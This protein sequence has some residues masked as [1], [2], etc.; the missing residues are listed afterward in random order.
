MSNSTSVFLLLLFHHVEIPACYQGAGQC[1]ALPSAA[2]PAQQALEREASRIMLEVFSSQAGLA[3][4]IFFAF[5]SLLPHHEH[6]E[7]AI[8][9]PVVRSMDIP[10]VFFR[11]ELCAW[12]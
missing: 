12:R 2:S 8:S 9:A 10:A 11:G 5:F 4:V 1:P 3:P 7:E 6:R